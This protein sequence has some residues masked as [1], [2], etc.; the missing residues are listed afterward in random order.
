MNTPLEIRHSTPYQGAA[1]LAGHRLS[2]HPQE[3][4]DR[5]RI[6]TLTFA[7]KSYTAHPG[8]TIASALTAHGVKILS[9]SF[10]YHRPRG[11]MG[12]G[13]SPAS[14][15]QIGNEPSVNAWTR[16]VE[17]GLV[18][19]PINVWPSL[20]FDLMSLSQLGSR[21][22]PVGFYYKTFIHPPQLWPHYEQ[23]LRQAAGL[24]RIDIKAPLVDG[25]DKQYLH[26]DIAVIGG[27]PA[28]LQAALTASQSGARVLLFDEN[29]AL[30]GHLQYSHDNQA[31]LAT[32]TSALEQQADNLVVYTNT[33]VLGWFEENWLYATNGQRLYKIRVKAT[34]FA[35]GATEQPPLFDNN[36]LPGIM[37]GETAKRLLHLYGV[38]LGRQ[39]LIVTANDDG[40]HLAADLQAAGVKVI[41]VADHRQHEINIPEACKN[42]PTY[43][44]H[45]IARADGGKQVKNALLVPV[46]AASNAKADK[47]DYIVCDSILLSTAWAPTNGLLYQAGADIVYDETRHEF[48]PQTTLPD[49]IFAAGRV[50]GTHQI[51]NQIAEADWV[52][53]AAAA[54]LQNSPLPSNDEY[55][56]L[57]A[58]KSAE[59]VRTSA[60]YAMVGEKS[61]KRF[62]DL[63]EDV[64]DKDV[65]DAIA[66]GYSSIELLKRY[67]TISMGP[68]QGRWSS[69][70]TIHLTAKLNQQSVAETGKTTSRPPVEPV[71]LGVLAGQMM[72][73][74]RYTPPHEWHLAHKGTMMVSGLWMRPEHYGD[75]QAEVRA[76]REGAGVIDV[77]TL[78]KIK[79]TGP[80]VPQVLNKFYINKWLKLNV[81]RVR[82]GIMCNTEGVVL[83]D[84]VT[85]RV[86]EQEWYMSTTSSG[87]DNIYEWIQWWLQSGWGE[88][89]Q[90][91]SL[92]ESYAAFNLAGPRS[93]EILASLTESD[94]SNK[95]F[96]Y[97]GVCALNVAGAP[98]RVMR[99]G[100]TGELSYEIHCPSSMGR[101][102]WEA[103]M[104]VGQ[105]FGI[106]PF[107]MEAQRILRLEKAHIIVGQDTDATSD[108]ISAG[109]NWAVKLDKPDFLGQRLLTRISEDGP[110]QKLV[111]FKMVNGDILSQDVT[112][113]EGLQIVTKV[114]LSEAHPLGLK[115]IGWV[116]SSRYSPTLQESI[117]L[118]WL[119]AEMA[120]QAGTRFTIRRN[121]QLIQ[122]QVHHGAF[123]DPD[124]RRLR[125]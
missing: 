116:T 14:M 22:L 121:D 89:V 7:G 61:G 111:G 30:G 90:A 13:H 67:S 20:D 75:P 96:P 109:Q 19:E 105:P 97:M 106:A 95:A 72:E 37:L 88:G 84:G 122:A 6:I 120:D 69:T 32:L 70:N 1:R 54:Y 79:L 99:I 26:G 94:V 83:D 33:S 98:C 46:E 23:V 47:R 93:R 31:Y 40:W 108:P 42:I 34:I 66:E 85:A 25:F 110:I 78:G 58:R 57:V 119:P 115:I 100:F 76:V 35:T 112:P 51:D 65:A 41:A 3:V 101:H 60:C 50:A 63:D 24:G 64:T 102:V 74:V 44:G 45:T 92:S 82:Y 8:D 43:L 124:G 59:P 15:V 17:P 80:N 21:F 12:F 117:G 77:S 71:T 48:L 91:T 53:R 11:L 104:A 49:G 107:G 29:P 9:R 36:D 68:S 114:P 87:A 4:I 62:I 2:Q 38:T 113:E 56:E 5:S 28:G 118:C 86:G 18:V 103:L 125:Q 55:A 27:G 16:L 81:G 123:V 39:I 73:P 52:G 10:K